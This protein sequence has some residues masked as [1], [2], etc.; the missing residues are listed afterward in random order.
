ME[1]VVLGYSGMPKEAVRRT[2]AASRWRASVSR[3]AVCLATMLRALEQPKSNNSLENVTD[4]LSHVSCLQVDN[5]AT[6]T[7]EF[8]F[9]SDNPQSGSLPAVKSANQSMPA[10]QVLGSLK[11]VAH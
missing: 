10:P 5:G 9:P 3:A 2:N 11:P 8:A 6:I 7:F 1:L 4:C